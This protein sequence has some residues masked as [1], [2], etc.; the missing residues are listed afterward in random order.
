[1]TLRS[2]FKFVVRERLG[3]RRPSVVT[4]D[5]HRQRAEFVVRQRAIEREV[6]RI[7]A[8]RSIWAEE[9]LKGR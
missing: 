6:E 3:H 5:D 7:D 9:H 1:M 8:V 2:F 4:P